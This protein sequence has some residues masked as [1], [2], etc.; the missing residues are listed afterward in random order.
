V[1][2]WSASQKGNFGFYFT[3]LLI[4]L[5]FTLPWVSGCSEGDDFEN[6]P[7]ATTGGVKDVSDSGATLT[8]RI[9]PNFSPTSGWFEWGTDP[10]LF[11][12]EETQRQALG[13]GGESLELSATIEG[14]ENCRT[15]YY[16]VCAKN[17]GGTTVG[18]K[19]SFSMGSSEECI[20]LTPP[21]VPKA[22]LSNLTTNAATLSGI[23][24]SMGKE[25]IAW[26]EWSEDE[27][28]SS[29][30]R[31][32]D[33]FIGSSSFPFNVEISIQGLIY[34][35]N[36]YYR[37]LARNED[38]IT[39]SEADYFAPPYYNNYHFLVNRL[40]DPE[41]EVLGKISLRQ[42]IDKLSSNGTIAFAPMMDGATIELDRIGDENSILRGEVFSPDFRTFLGFQTRDYGKSALYA[43]KHL[44][45]NASELPNGVTFKWTGGEDNPARVLGVY[46]NL[47]M[48]NVTITGGISKAEA[49]EDP[50][51]E[52]PFT[53]ARGGG[54][55]VWGKMTLYNCIV[56]GNKIEGDLNPSR[57]RGA[58]GGGIYGDRLDIYDSVISG[59]SA[60]GFGAAGGGIYSVSAREAYGDG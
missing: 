21:E 44:N 7:L 55:A 1:R 46:G 3:L 18:E 40:G 23:V 58:F 57:D 43:R 16:W 6:L 52:Q 15:Y 2:H 12:Y 8:A 51:S 5:I 34:E 33:I 13:E 20:E 19:L 35:K 45:I 11:A 47:T 27:T 42:A 14:L 50:E 60:E 59:N 28:F 53:L 22:Y 29:P 32:A 54:L 31:S 56:H 38:G 37:V 10:S 49:I 4:L 41:D 26:F 48:R 9:N 24:N 39:A 36:Y 30:N 25:T 17:E